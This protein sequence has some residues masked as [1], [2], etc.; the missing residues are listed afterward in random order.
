MNM[1]L[2]MLIIAYSSYLCDERRKVLV[3][4]VLLPKNIS[5]DTIMIYTNRKPVRCAKK[6]L[7][8]RYKEKKKKRFVIIFPIKLLLSHKFLIHHIPKNQI[9]SF[10]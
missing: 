5:Q 2:C 4:F 6:L 9:I 8:M 10:I 7:K 3:T 1:T